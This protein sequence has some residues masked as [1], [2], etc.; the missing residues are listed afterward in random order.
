MRSPCAPNRPGIPVNEMWSG[1]ATPK[2]VHDGPENGPSQTSG[3]PWR[4]QTNPAAFS[5]WAAYTVSLPT[6]SLTASRSGNGISL[7]LSESS[8]TPIA[9][10]LSV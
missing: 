2:Y 3:R 6:V 10:R 1:S 4:S 5:C 9:A 7:G 8:A